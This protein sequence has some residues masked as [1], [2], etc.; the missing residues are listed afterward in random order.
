MLHRGAEHSGRAPYILA[1]EYARTPRALAAPLLPDK[2][3]MPRPTGVHPRLV[4]WSL[5]PVASLLLA[6]GCAASGHTPEAPVPASEPR[7]EVRLRVELVRAQGCEEAFDLA[8]YRTRAVELIAWEPGA[9][10]CTDRTLTIRYLSRQASRDDVLRA[11]AAAGATV[12]TL[13]ASQ[14]DAR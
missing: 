9:G 3:S 8:L 2:D 13:P 4:N 11:A 7:A 12:T 10:R 14:G 6:A 5:L 1:V